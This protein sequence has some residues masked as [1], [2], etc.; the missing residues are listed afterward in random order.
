MRKSRREKSII[1]EIIANVEELN[2]SDKYKNIIYDFFSSTMRLKS[3]IPLLCLVDDNVVINW[4]CGSAS[5]EVEFNDTGEWYMRGKNSQG[6]EYTSKNYHTIVHEI[7]L[8]LREME[9]TLEKNNP[10]WQEEY[11]ESIQQVSRIL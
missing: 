11:L 3:P 4:I 8:L 7:S 6:K 10:H 9:D 5:I 1:R 2:I